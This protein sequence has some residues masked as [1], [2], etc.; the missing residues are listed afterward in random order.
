MPSHRK[1]RVASLIHQE[2]A[3]ILREEVKD[4]RIG[5]WLSI[6][7]VKVVDDLSRATAFFTVQGGDEN[8]RLEVQSGLARS[9]PFLRGRLGAALQMRSVPTLV[10]LHDDAFE[11][12]L[13]IHALINA[14]NP[15]P[16]LPGDQDEEGGSDESAP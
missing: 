16:A 2:L 8:R 6:T 11:H 4:P 7:Q 9:L 3:R 15:P 1:E 13:K 10:F 12:A 14:V 5:P